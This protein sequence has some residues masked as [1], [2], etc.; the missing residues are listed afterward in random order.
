MES[1]NGLFIYWRESTVFR[2]SELSIS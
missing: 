2:S 1:L